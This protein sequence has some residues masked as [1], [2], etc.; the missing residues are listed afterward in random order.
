MSN[1]IN[2]KGTPVFYKNLNSTAKII[3]NRG[4]A[5]SSKSFSTLQLLVYKLLK[6]EKKSIIILRK[7]LPALRHSTY[8]A[9]LGLIEDMGVKG[10]LEE[11][12]Q[13]LTYRY[14]NSVLRFGSVDNAEKI[15]STEFNYIFLEEATDF[16]YQDYQMIKL[17]LRA[18]SVDGKKNQMFL[19][20]NPVSETHWIKTKLLANEPDCQEIVSTYKENPYIPEDYRE[21]LEELIN[22]D[23]NYYRVYAL[24]EWG[25][26][27]GLIYNGNYKIIG[28]VPNAKES[29]SFYGLDF[30]F[31][32]PCALI[33]C[34]PTQNTPEL[35]EIGVKELIYKS[36][37]TT[38]ELIGEMEKVIPPE[39]RHRP[40]YCFHPDTLVRTNTESE[41]R[42]ND[43]N[44]GDRLHGN[45][46]I[47]DIVRTP[48]KGE[49]LNIKVK[50]ILD[51]IRCTLNHKI[52]IIRKKGRITRRSD[53]DLCNSI[54]LVNA[55]D[56]QK[57]DYL[58]TPL[59]G[60]END[61]KL[62][63][64]SKSRYKNGQIKNKIKFK[65]D[66]SIF[67]LLGYYAA[68]GSV[69][70]SRKDGG[71][72]KFY[73]AEHEEFTHVQDVIDIIKKCFGVECTKYYGHPG[74]IAIN[75]YSVILANFFREYVSG[76][77]INKKVHPDLMN[78]STEYQ[79]EFL[80][81][82][83]RGDGGLTIKEKDNRGSSSYKLSG[84]TASKD[85]GR[86]MF[87]MALRCELHPYMTT[88]I[89]KPSPKRNVNRD[90]VA[91]D[92][93]FSLKG[94]TDL[95]FYTTDKKQLRVRRVID[96]LMLVQVTQ[97]SFEEYE[98]DVIDIDVDKDDL[99]VAEN[100][101]VHNCDSAEPDRIKAIR[102]AGFNAK[103]AKK[104]K[105]IIDGIDFVKS[106]FLFIVRGSDN[107]IKELNSY[108]WKVTKDGD[109][110]DEP[111][112]TFNHCLD[113]L[114]Y[115]LITH[116]KK[117]NFKFRWIGR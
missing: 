17:R 33:E 115:A 99:F 90:T 97:L 70:I 86:Q 51:P 6:E 88:R 16:S 94:I 26:L 41:V 44:I 74:A 76:V 37:L 78:M 109:T 114:R 82:W 108:S 23:Q 14:G 100:V 36:E 110:L 40:I 68:E 50:S 7:T 8:E 59:K 105:S 38:E 27:D 93:H 98:G 34:I 9:F 57:G 48:H 102:Q 15:K 104:G 4:G 83:L 10:L 20:F 18:P 84:T 56:I 95:G 35:R 96:N 79:K 73:F 13:Y 113:S 25:R 21:M 43:L 11:S 29:Q 42:I 54:E 5:G 89:C 87:L 60:I 111:I 112:D 32:D 47:L 67:R 116:L 69:Y 49:L 107:V 28:E 75:V 62:E 45:K 85:L 3:V 61:I 72:T 12:K 2:L 22:Q 91:F 63:L 92:V 77:A 64:D 117:A 52:P 103:P 66:S 24:G 106:C 30:G 31:N 81:G 58:L 19:C 71:T 46:T 101:L 80:I 1:K 55:S 39:K 65:F 53:D